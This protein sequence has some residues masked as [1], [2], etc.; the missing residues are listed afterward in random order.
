MEWQNGVI[1][2]DTNAGRSN[3]RSVSAYMLSSHGYDGTGCVRME[4]D[5]PCDVAQWER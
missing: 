5:W 1:F 3:L 2:V 4:C